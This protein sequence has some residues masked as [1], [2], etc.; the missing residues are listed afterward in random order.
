MPSLL[1]RATRIAVKA[2]EGQMRKEAPIPYI[3]HPFRIALML[4]QYDFPESVIAAA[5]THDVLEDTSVTEKELLA[6]IGS[7]AFGI[8][9]AVTYDDSLSWEEARKAYVES[10]SRGPEGSIAVSVADKVHNLESLLDAYQEQGDKVWQHFNAGM[11]KKIWFE[12]LVLGMAKAKWEHPLVYRYETLLNE[13][14]SLTGFSEDR[15]V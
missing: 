12:N 9:K 11:E 4:A 13:L 6:A 1:D 14:K 3:T 2:H 8:V 7:E 5:L 15:A 10:V